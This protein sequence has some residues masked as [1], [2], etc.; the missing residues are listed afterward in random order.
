M[1]EIQFISEMKSS[2]ADPAYNKLIEQVIANTHCT[3]D[4]IPSL[5]TSYLAS[6][7]MVINFKLESLQ[8]FLND[9]HYRNIFET[10]RGNGSNNMEARKNVESTCFHE[11]YNNAEASARPKYG[12]LNIYNRP[13]GVISTQGYGRSFFVLKNNVRSRVTISSSDT[14]G[15]SVIGTIDNCKHIIA[16]FSPGEISNMIKIA[17][18]VIEFVDDFHTYKELQI[19][20]DIL[21]IR[22]IK[23]INVCLKDIT[24][25]QLTLADQFATKN[26]IT[27]NFFE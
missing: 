12:S 16:K 22:D 3:I 2:E 20:G 17:T 8:H 1:R 11:M 23:S 25:E 4:N 18:G 13:N 14:F 27:I 5:L 15:S 19:H 7:P 21:F 6:A 24:D 9:T 10:G 26:N